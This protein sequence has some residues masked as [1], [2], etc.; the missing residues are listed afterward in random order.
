MHRAAAIVSDSERQATSHV[1]WLSWLLGAALL[2]AVIAAAL[3]FSEERAFVRVA[4]ETEP[5]W[6]AVAVLLQAGTY[7]AQGG[8]W[9]L[10]G[11]ATACPLSRW[12]AVE[13][14]LAKLFADQALP[15]AGL[16]SSI[17]IAKALERREFPSA[18]VKASVLIN[19]A[20]Y[21]LAY[22]F[23]LAGALSVLTWHGQG[24]A[25]V[26]V[27][28]MLFLLFSI[29][30]SLM[31]LAMA[32]R[33]LERVGLYARRLP[34]VQTTLA[35][36]RGADGR[37]VRNPRV[38][39]TAIGLQGAIVLLDAATVWTLIGALGVSA[40]VTGVFAS[41]MI[42]SLF[43]TMGIVPGGLGMFEAT[44]VLTLRMA[45]V[46]LAV[47]LSATLLFRGLSFWLPMVPGYWFSRRA[48]ARR[49]SDSL[50]WR[51]RYRSVESRPLLTDRRSRADGLSVTDA[52]ER[53]DIDG[54]NL[55]RDERGSSRVDVFCTG[56][57]E[58]LLLILVFVAT[59]FAA[60]PLSKRC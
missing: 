43:R 49:P 48:L 8:I 4:Q 19:I 29:G 30:L 15:S 35:F 16:S 31:I 18:A 44:S 46:D 47:A 21:H 5:W 6:L 38:L 22:V 42:A 12:T 1:A 24:N 32:G 59:C 9:R 58:S 26:V 2:V 51:Q 34:L 27:T 10:A 13:L 25:L 53:L 56:S 52:A 11:R 20:S 23:A 3:H 39:G 37:L 57:G 54:P 17:L 14:S 33:P 41:F 55:L 36:L 45:G 60:G 50:R 28:A 40:P 7:I